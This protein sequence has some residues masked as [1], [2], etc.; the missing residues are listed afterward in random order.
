MLPDQENITLAKIVY[1]FRIN[2][3]KTIAALNVHPK[4][5]IEDIFFNT[6]V[7]KEE[8]TMYLDILQNEPGFDAVFEL[9]KELVEDISKYVYDDPRMMLYRMDRVKLI[10]RNS[11]LIEFISDV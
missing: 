7:I 11:I 9:T 4:S 3:D 10:A 8:N 2:K 6:F 1:L 5:E